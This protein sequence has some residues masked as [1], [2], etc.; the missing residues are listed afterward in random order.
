MGAWRVGQKL[1]S[2]YKMVAFKKQ[3]VTNCYT[4][5]RQKKRRLLSSEDFFRDFL[6]WS[7]FLPCLSFQGR[8]FF[9]VCR[10][11]NFVSSISQLIEEAI[12]IGSNFHC[13]LERGSD[14]TNHLF[15]SFL[16]RFPM[17]LP[18]TLRYPSD[19]LRI[20]APAALPFG[21]I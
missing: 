20:I 6:A 4:R 9:S 21:C 10:I 14:D 7:L 16:L 13:N 1:Q 19:G 11:Q 15:I 3:A 12:L 5:L 8:A 17:S 2:G 18:E